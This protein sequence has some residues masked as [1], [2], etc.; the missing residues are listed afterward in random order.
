MKQFKHSLCWIRRDIRLSDHHALSAAIQ[1]SDQV[2][3]AFVFD[4][5]IL[6]R[7]QDKNDRRLT[8]IQHSL[9]VVNSELQSKKSQLVILHGDPRMEIPNAVKRLKADAVYANLDVEPYAKQRDQYVHEKLEQI[10]CKFFLLKDHVIFRGLEVKNKSGLPFKVFTPYKN[11]WLK[12]LTPEHAQDLTVETDNF[13][14]YTKLKIFRKD[15]TLPDL[16]FE[17][18]SL[19]LDPGELE[20][21]RSLKFFAKNMANY[22]KE[23]DFPWLPNGTSGLSVHLRFGTI[24]IRACVREALKNKSLGARTW[25]SELIWREFYQMILDQFPHVTE[26]AF[27]PEYA[28]IQWPGSDENFEHWFRGFT[29]YPIIDAA[30]RLF[31]KTG[32]MHNRL[33]MIVAQFL[34][35]DLLIDWRQGEKFFARQLLDFD[36]AS[37][38]GGWQWC[39]S[40][41][42]DAQPYFRIFNPILQSRKFD[43]KGDFIRSQCPELQN[44]SDKDIHAPWE[45]SLDVQKKA[46]CIVGKDYPKPIVDHA[47][48]RQKALLL[49][50]KIKL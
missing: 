12:Q 46:K 37:N 11:Q 6:N 16:G 8:F 19:W 4:T 1:N 42:C 13:T 35:K 41:G 33:R 30:M 22:H 32:W 23:R 28:D 45:N 10:G 17:K 2:T 39:S 27:K 49:Y 40:T 36:L 21:A 38:N 31:S 29:G 48:Q 50:K 24:S 20:A 5:N 43:A 7:L 18:N 9:Q 34:C 3:V 14:P 15:W 47:T 25:L 44:F 26:T